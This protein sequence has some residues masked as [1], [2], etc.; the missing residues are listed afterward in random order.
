MQLLHK[1]T[2]LEDDLTAQGRRLIATWLRK[3]NRTSAKLN[4]QE[5]LLQQQQFI[6]TNNPLHG[7]TMLIEINTRKNKS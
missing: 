6:T 5:R 7:K 3:R 2:F 1:D 4:T